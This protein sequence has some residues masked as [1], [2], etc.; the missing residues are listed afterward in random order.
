MSARDILS[1]EEIDTLLNEEPGQKP[2]P[3]QA[4]LDG[5]PLNFYD[6]ISEYHKSITKS[7]GFKTINLMFTSELRDRLT[8]FL[9]KKIQV[10]ATEPEVSTFEQYLKCNDTRAM[11]SLHKIKPSNTFMLI[12][13]DQT[14]LSSAIELLF[15]GS[16]SY[17]ADVNREFGHTDIKTSKILSDIICDAISQ[18]WDRVLNF[19]FEFIKTSKEP[20]MPKIINSCEKIIISHYTIK[21]D[22]INAQLDICLPHN[23]INSVSD[24]LSNEERKVE[25]PHSQEQWQADLKNNIYNANINLSAEI[26]ETKIKLKDVVNLKVGDIIS[27][28]NPNVGTLLAENMKLFKVRCCAKDGAKVAQ[29]MDRIND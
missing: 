9:H 8:S 14:L 4:V 28:D 13:L 24:K 19:N 11:L 18:S 25:N 22:D 10:E 1:D 12:M 5:V 17:S 7:R 6:F 15:G 27:I 3:E 20:M 26:T 23:L 16:V 2:A 21:I 29:I